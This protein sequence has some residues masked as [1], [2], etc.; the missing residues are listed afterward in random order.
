MELTAWRI[1][2]ARYAN[3]AFDGEGAR[4]YGGRFNSPGTPVVYVASSLSLA[5]LEVLVHVDRGRA[6]AQHVACPVTYDAADVLVLERDALPA[7]WDLP[8]PPPAVQK[9]GDLWVASKASL[10][11]R[12]PSVLLPGDVLEREHNFLINPLHEGFGRVTIGPARE[13]TF[14]ARFF[15]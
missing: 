8:V 6:L 12:V 2:L 4:R 1:T 5:M 13:L 11:L 3:T 15:R 7:G 9:L 10:L 14:D